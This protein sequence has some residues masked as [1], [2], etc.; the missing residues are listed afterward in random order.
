M[1]NNGIVKFLTS[2]KAI[3]SI[4]VVLVALIVWFVSMGSEVKAVKAENKHQEEASEALRHCVSA[5][6]QTLVKV[7][8]R[9]ESVNENLERIDI[10]QEVIRKEITERLDTIYDKVK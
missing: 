9:L 8:T 5:N 2:A 1:P 4:L 6:T 3:V 7:E 10:R